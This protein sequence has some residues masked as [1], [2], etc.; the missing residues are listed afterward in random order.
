VN[1]FDAGSASGEPQ[2]FPA[3]ETAAFPVQTSFDAA[4]RRA[5]EGLISACSAAYGCLAWIFRFVSILGE[6]Y[7]HG[8]SVFWSETRGSWRNAHDA[9]ED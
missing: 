7:T 6:R 2:V 1:A 9:A 5:A 8:R 3:P 4:S